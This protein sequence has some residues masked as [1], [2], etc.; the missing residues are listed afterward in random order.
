MLLVSRSRS[1][2]LIGVCVSL[3]VE[4]SVGTLITFSSGSD[5]LSSS[6]EIPRVQGYF[7]PNEFSKLVSTLASGMNKCNETTVY[8]KLS[9]RWL[10]YE[11]PK[12]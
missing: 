2:K 1:S 12:A 7:S 4:V 5:K 9:W 6:F 11:A 8:L 10:T 3:M